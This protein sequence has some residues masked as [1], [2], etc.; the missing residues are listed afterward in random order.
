MLLW[1]RPA[2]GQQQQRMVF[3]VTAVVLVKAS[4]Q[5]SSCISCRAALCVLMPLAVLCFCRVSTWCCVPHVLGSC[6]IMPAGMTHQGHTGGRVHCVQCVE[7]QPSSTWGASSWHEPWLCF[8][9]L[10]VD[11]GSRS[12]MYGVSGTSPSGNAA[13]AAQSMGLANMKL[14]EHSRT[15]QLCDRSRALKG[16]C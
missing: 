8:G 6:S 3:G 7:S 2:A 13:T 5:Q 9:L 11:Q 12:S 15:L 4:Q 10:L 14:T 1:E 16:L